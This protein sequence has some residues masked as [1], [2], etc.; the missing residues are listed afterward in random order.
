VAA[1]AGA[2]ATEQARNVA[3]E[4]GLELGEHQAR[5]L[6]EISLAEYDQVYVMSSSHLRYLPEGHRGSVLSTLAGK[7]KDVEDPYGRGLESYRK[8]FAEIRRYLDR[9]L[10]EKV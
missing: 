8:A 7:K 9:L 5:P 4:V 6:G 1:V 3:A 2:P 10:D